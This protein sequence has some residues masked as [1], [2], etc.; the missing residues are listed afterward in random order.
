[1]S[2]IQQIL[3]KESE[4]KSIIKEAEEKALETKQ[5]A[6][7]KQANDLENFAKDLEKEKAERI[8]KQKELLIQKHKEITENGEKDT[9]EIIAKAA[10]NKEPAIDLVL[11]HISK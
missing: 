3:E 11:K 8:T 4:A 6:E 1:M 7:K 9:K 10:Q 2:S 5:Q